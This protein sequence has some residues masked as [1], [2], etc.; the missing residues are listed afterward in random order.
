MNSAPVTLLHVHKDHTL[1]DSFSIPMVA[2]ADVCVMSVNNQVNSLIYG[3]NIK[4][5]KDK[6]TD[7]GIRGCDYPN[8]PFRTINY[9][10]DWRVVC[11]YNKVLYHLRIEND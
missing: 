7:F 10:S 2:C 3:Y 4:N 11:T 9:P 6:P 8:Y 5:A 1:V